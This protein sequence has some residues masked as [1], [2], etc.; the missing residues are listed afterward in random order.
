MNFELPP[1]GQ[2]NP[3]SGPSRTPRAVPAARPD[4][5]A[6]VEVDVSIP[7]SPPAELRAEMAAAAQRVEELRAQDRELHFELDD[8]GR[9]ILEVRDLEGNVIRSIPPS[10][11]L[12]VA[13]GASLEA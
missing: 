2:P 3:T 6:A 10:H 9:I 5:G 8:N 4:L 7:S 13:A 12:D 1:V 11:V